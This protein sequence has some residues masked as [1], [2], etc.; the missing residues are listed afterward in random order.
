MGVIVNI[1]LGVI[2]ITRL[3][4]M[5]QQS[6]KMLIFLLAIFLPIQITNIVIVATQHGNISGEDYILSGMH[7]CIYYVSG[8][9]QFLFGMTWI[10]VTAWEVLALFLSIW[11]A[12]KH[13][14]DMPQ[15]TRWT[16]SDCFAMLI[17]THAFYFASV[18]VASSLEL[19]FLSPKITAL[20]IVGTEVYTGISQIARL[21]MWF[22]LGPRL[23]LGVREHNAKLVADSDEGTAMTS[24]AFQ[25]RVHITTDNGV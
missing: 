10:L 4:A 18:V 3:Y 16:A 23:I 14:R 7:M 22:V 11:I 15:P 12:V 24:I 20:G 13:F 9:V 21:V 1:M 2:M 25:E 19:G 8:D 5:Y 17:K 6:R